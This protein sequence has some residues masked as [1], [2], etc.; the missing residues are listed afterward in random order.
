MPPG[1]F[2]STTIDYSVCMEKNKH[3]QDGRRISFFFFNDTATTEIYTLSLHDALP[4]SRDDAH[5]HALLEPCAEQDAADRRNAHEQ[6]VVDVEVAV[7]RLGRRPDGR[8]HDDGCERGPGGR[9][10]VVAEP[11]DQQR[12]HDR[13][14]TDAE[15]PA[16]H[17]GRGPDPEELEPAV[18]RHAGHTRGVSVHA[19]ASELLSALIDDPA[20]SAVLLDVDGTLAP[21]VRHADDA[22]VPPPTRSLL[23]AIAK[24]YALVACVSGRRATDTRRVVSIGSIAYI[25]NHGG[26]VLPPSGTEV[27]VNPELRAWTR[28]IQDFARA[29]DTPELRR[30]RVRLEDKGSITA[31]HWRGGA[32]PDPARAAGPRPPPQ[33]RT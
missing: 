16:E 17:P 24:R 23:S 14:P 32:A 5:R 20:H 12:D 27:R 31:F 30:L 29:A 2:G 25:G 11:E 26:E 10:L 9:P 19:P 22:M 18:A 28:R 3:P 7:E 1:L 4:I 21:I 8:D 6:P 33:G 13:P 15:Q